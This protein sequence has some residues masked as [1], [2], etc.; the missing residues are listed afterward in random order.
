MWIGRAVGLQRHV[1]VG[2][3]GVLF[4]ASSCIVLFMSDDRARLLGLR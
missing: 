4:S 2:A 3:V 1:Q